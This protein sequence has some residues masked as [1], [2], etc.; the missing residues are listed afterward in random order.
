MPGPKPK[1]NI[2][3]L[4][5][6]TSIDKITI[7]C[8]SN[9]TYKRNTSNCGESNDVRNRTYTDM[10]ISDREKIDHIFHNIWHDIPTPDKTTNIVNA[11]NKFV[12]ECIVSIRRNAAIPR[13]DESFN[14][15]ERTTDSRFHEIDQNILKRIHHNPN[16]SNT[17]DGFVQYNS[18]S[19]LDSVPI[20]RTDEQTNVSTDEQTNVSTDKRPIL[21]HEMENISVYSKPDSRINAYTK[22]L[23]KPPSE[24]NCEEPKS[25]TVLK[26]RKKKKIK[27]KSTQNQSSTLLSK[28]GVETSGK[29]E[30]KTNEKRI[31]KIDIE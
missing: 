1:I 27:E 26:K 24:V 6:S 11:F 14:C 21:I 15:L 8:L 4:I 22:K 17:L 28:R 31:V 30:K 10:N 3:P 7:D 23:S 18:V 16:S 13:I 29:N 5:N 20:Y 9:S 25:T 12:D 19:K 2:G